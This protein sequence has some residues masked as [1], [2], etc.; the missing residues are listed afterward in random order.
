MPANTVDI[1]LDR[2]RLLR[3]DHNAM[4]DLDM[5]FLRDFKKSIFQILVSLESLGDSVESANGN[6]NAADIMNK[7][8][9]EMVSFAGVRIFMWAGLRHEDKSLTLE[10][11]GDLLETA[12]EKGLDITVC[13]TKIFEAIMKCNSFKALGREA[14]AQPATKT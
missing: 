1:E 5:I 11:V 3:Y 8:P 12:A 4:A 7:L 10:S 2:P 6:E 13:I 9:V 14:P